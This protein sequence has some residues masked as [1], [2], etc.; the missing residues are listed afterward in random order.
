MISHLVFHFLSVAIAAIVKKVN[1]SNKTPE[2]SN[3]ECPVL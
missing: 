1:K 3:A 2:M